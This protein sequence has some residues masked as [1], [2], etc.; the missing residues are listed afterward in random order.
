MEKGTTYFPSAHRHDM[1]PHASATAGRNSRKKK[2]LQRAGKTHWLGICIA[3]QQRL[4]EGGRVQAGTAARC[5]G[6]DFIEMGGKLG[7]F[8]AAAAALT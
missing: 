8:A 5:Q 1:L 6:T 2:T 7:S 3:I 4:E